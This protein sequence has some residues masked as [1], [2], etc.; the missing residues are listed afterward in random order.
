METALRASGY[1]LAAAVGNRQYG[2]GCRSRAA[3]EVAEVR[4]AASAFPDRALLGLDIRNTFDAVRWA[5]MMHFLLQSQ[6]P[7]A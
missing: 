7:R 5:D 4:A 3:L 2:A 6:K 1:Q